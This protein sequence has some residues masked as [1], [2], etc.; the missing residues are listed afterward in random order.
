MSV[1]A[2]AFSF[3]SW[4]HVSPSL[5]T[6]THF[7]VCVHGERCTALISSIKFIC[8]AFERLF[9]VKFYTHSGYIHFVLHCCL[10][11]VVIFSVCLFVFGVLLALDYET[12][13]LCYCVL[14]LLTTIFFSL[15][16]CLFFVYF[17]GSDGWIFFR[18]SLLYLS[19]SPISFDIFY[20]NLCAQLLARTRGGRMYSNESQNSNP[21]RI[22]AALPIYGFFNHIMGIS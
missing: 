9:C 22:Q 3:A 16:F 17:V 8:S 6:S 14:S 10:F 18:L 2:I 7:N 19:L 20:F 4:A 21:N 11:R 1:S 13:A 5:T 15:I 12:Q